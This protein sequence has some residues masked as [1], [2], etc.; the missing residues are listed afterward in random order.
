MDQELDSLLEI[1]LARE[2]RWRALIEQQSRA[3]HRLTS[4][5]PSCW[6][7]WLWRVTLHYICTGIENESWHA[8]QEASK[9]AGALN[10]LI[11]KGGD[12]PPGQEWPT[13]QCFA[14]VDIDELTFKP[15]PSSSSSSALSKLDLLR[16]EYGLDIHAAF[17]EEAESLL[18]PTTPEQWLAWLINDSIVMLK[19]GLQPDTSLRTGWEVDNFCQW[20][21]DELRVIAHL[22]RAGICPSGEIPCL[23]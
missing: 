7:W 16:E 10:L 8:F 1:L 4:Q 20:A 5:D 6:I 22:Y 9:L 17:R 19:N 3:E 12:V 23:P 21:S 11:N 18:R 2:P 14:K 15:A 13:P